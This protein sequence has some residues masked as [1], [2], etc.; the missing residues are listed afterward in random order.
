MVIWF[1]KR[2]PVAVVLSL[3]MGVAIPGQAPGG[4]ALKDAQSVP[5][6]R[7][8]QECPAT[9]PTCVVF[10]IGLVWKGERFV[11]ADRHPSV[12]SVEIDDATGYGT[13]I[14]EVRGRL[15]G[16]PEKKFRV[17]LPYPMDQLNCVD[18]SAAV[19]GV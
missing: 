6:L 3:L 19:V 12:V 1:R 18:F 13:A 5:A 2:I 17:V 9:E 16:G 4:E 15:N 7:V 14:V 11:D 10:D 8:L